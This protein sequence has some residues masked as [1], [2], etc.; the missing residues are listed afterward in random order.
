MT[1][2]GQ[3]V[4][5]QVLAEGLAWAK[6][7]VAGGWEEERLAQEENVFARRVAQRHPTSAASPVP[8]RNARAAGS[9]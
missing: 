8:A 3:L 1:A 6:A 4:R 9:L 2:L 5:G 7:K